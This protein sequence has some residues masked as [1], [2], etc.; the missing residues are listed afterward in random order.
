MVEGTSTPEKAVDWLNTCM[1]IL[2]DEVFL[3]EAYEMISNAAMNLID[4]VADEELI[5][6][7]VELTKDLSSTL[8]KTLSKV[9]V[10]REL[11]V[12]DVSIS[13]AA[14]TEARAAKKEKS[15]KYISSFQKLTD[16]VAENLP[17]GT[18]SDPTVTDLFTFVAGK[19]SRS[20]IVYLKL[21]IYV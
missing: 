21:C 7:N 3:P 17:V 4:Q 6:E 15:D 19:V 14:A 9:G 8:F 5:K 13:V 10:S 16:K 20:Q 18:E 12:S 2:S 11:E 1:E